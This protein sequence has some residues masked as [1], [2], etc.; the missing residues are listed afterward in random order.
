MNNDPLQAKNPYPYRVTAGL[1][2]AFTLNPGEPATLVQKPVG[3]LNHADPTTIPVN[4]LT[5][6]SQ[7]C[8]IPMKDRVVPRLGS[9]LLG[10]AATANQNW[11]IVGH[12]ERYTTAGG[13]SM[14][15]RVTK[16]SDYLQNDIIEVLYP[17]PLTGINQWYKISYKIWNLI[18]STLSDWTSVAPGIHEY[19]MDDWFDTN[20]N[21]ALSLN[22]P[23]LI[24]TNG[25]P[26]IY[27]WLGA[28]A[29]IIDIY[30]NG[31]NYYLTTSYGTMTYTPSTGTA[32][33]RG[34]VVTGGTSGAT[35]LVGGTSVV[36]SIS[37]MTLIHVSGVF[38]FGEAISGGSS[39][40]LATVN[41]YL[42]PANT[43]ASLGFTLLS[44]EAPY[45]II[46]G[47]AYSTTG[48]N[49]ATNS[50]ILTSVSTPAINVGDVAF[51]VPRA[52]AQVMPVDVCRQNQNYMFYGS[53]N[54]RRLEMS[55]SF[56]HDAFQSITNST[57]TLNTM[58]LSGAF[59]GTGYHTYI[60]TVTAT[61]A[62]DTYQWSYDGATPTTGVAMTTGAHLL[63][64]G[65]SIAF[66]ETTGHVLGDSWTITVGQAVTNAWANFY[67]TT[68][69]RAPGEGYVFQLPSN[70]WA[71][72][73]QESVMYVNGN[74]GEWGT[75]QTTLAAN[76]LTETVVYTP[77]KQ[78]AMSKVIYPYMIG[79]MDN[80]LIYVTTNKKLD[81]IQRMKFL[82]L[83]QIGNLSN[84]VKNDFTY[85]SF[86]G[87][88]LKYFDKKLFITSPVEGK[89]LCYDELQKY[90]QPPQVIP[91]NAILSIVGNTLISHSNLRNQTF[92]LFSNVNGGD[93]GQNYEV[94]M[95]TGYDSGGDRYG[96]KTSNTTFVEGYVSGAP[97][98]NMNVFIGVNGSGGVRSHIITPKFDLSEDAGPIGEGY[99]GE[100]QLGSDL[101]NPYPH[102]YEI[103]RASTP[104]MM[105]YRFVQ[106]ELNCTTKYHSYVWLNVG[107]NRVVS[108]IGNNDITATPV[109]SQT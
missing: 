64:N 95:R 72:E 5:Y 47:I 26:F 41:Y 52:D 94:I 16:S 100:T 90:W 29:P 9:T 51:S 99:L 108:D 82:E 61:G 12:K 31:T 33:V 91:E 18:A 1:R 69:G 105:N 3:Y 4:A 44:G 88:R 22:T 43:W 70:F 63:S 57:A 65:I 7:N 81:M 106:Y 77:L 46:D 76:L 60:I 107:I 74:Y 68:I 92:T 85:C 96:Y 27:S 103:D 25:L 13:I 67:Y 84:P 55:N 42:P 86:T 71:M 75:I 20:L 10:A 17:N 37:T 54:S 21:P 8:F 39:G 101:Y 66:P 58:V 11:P 98:M 62:P 28:A 73:P 35:A 30:K 78:E 93:N 109:I 87:G 49:F 6:P 2:K 24:W 104:I 34:E 56:G 97:Q 89:M 53:W 83:P 50:Y 38:Q 15:V 48:G 102:F 23:R 59:T 32:W 79:H 40:A 19:Y 36:N 80:S 14:E 45:M